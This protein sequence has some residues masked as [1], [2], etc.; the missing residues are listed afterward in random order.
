MFYG[1]S[2]APFIILLI[3]IWVVGVIPASMAKRAASLKKKEAAL[4]QQKQQNP[5]KQ[6]K[7]DASGVPQPE[8]ERLSRLTP[9]VTVTA[10]DDSVYQG[11][12]NAVTGEGYDPCHEEQMTELRRA[13]DAG[14][15]PVPAAQTRVGIPLGWTDNDVVRGIVM[16]EILT[17]KSR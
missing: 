1:S 9:S 16:S 13:G 8:E 10:H 12:M 14:F 7:D 2:F 5:Q 4:R 15:E 6:G 17:R 11:S 3:L